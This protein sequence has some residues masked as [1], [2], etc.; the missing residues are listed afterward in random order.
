MATRRDFLTTAAAVLVPLSAHAR[1]PDGPAEPLDEVVVTATRLPAIVHDTPGARVNDREAIE[2][3]GA[4][5]D[6]D[7]L[8]DVPG[9]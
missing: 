1:T 6:G 7:V 2:R 8:A 3:R 9:L 5:F 4:V